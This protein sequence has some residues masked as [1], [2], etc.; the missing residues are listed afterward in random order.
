MSTQTKAPTSETLLLTVPGAAAWSDSFRIRVNDG[1]P[2]SVSLTGAQSSYLLFAHSYGFTLP[3]GATIDDIT[4][5]IRMRRTGTALDLSAHIFK[6]DDDSQPV[7]STV[8]TAI[9]TSWTDFAIT[10]FGGT[11]TDAEVEA[12]GFSM[13]LIASL[14]SGSV[15]IEIDWVTLTVNYNGDDYVGP[16]SPIILFLS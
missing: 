5:N 2:A 4:L 10:G 11:L 13:G 15:L 1:V 14:S 9:P 3:P 6:T 7:G 16:V 8:D 12:S